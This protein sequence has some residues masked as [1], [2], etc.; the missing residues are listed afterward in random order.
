MMT[1][2]GDVKYFLIGGDGRPGQ[3]ESATEWIKENC[4][5]AP[6]GEWQ[7]EQQTDS[8]QPFNMN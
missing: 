6:S 2:N 7:S 8:Q 4:E 1:R 3:S 5:E